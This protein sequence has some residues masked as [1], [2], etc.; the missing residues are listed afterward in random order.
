MAGIN[1]GLYFAQQFK[2]VQFKECKEKI[3]QFLAD[4]IA[5][6]GRSFSKEELMKNYAYPDVNL[7][8]LDMDWFEDT[9]FM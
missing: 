4:M 3:D 5:P 8:S 7:S 9:Y 2:E 6:D 1:F